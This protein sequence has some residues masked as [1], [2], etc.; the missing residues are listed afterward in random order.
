MLVTS[1]LRA[2]SQLATLVAS[3]LKRTVRCACYWT[4]GR[5]GNW[6]TC[7]ANDGQLGQRPRHTS[8]YFPRTFQEPTFRLG[9][10][11]IVA[12]GGLSC[13]GELLDKQKFC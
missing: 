6:L 1:L 9:I 13:E 12:N 10:R 4:H 2:P 8:T 11:A 5:A 3:K 7:S